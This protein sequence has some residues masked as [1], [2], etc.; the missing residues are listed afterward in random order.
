MKPTAVLSCFVSHLCVRRVI[1]SAVVCCSVLCIHFKSRAQAGC[2][3]LCT[4]LKQA[5]GPCCT[6]K[7][8]RVSCH[9]FFHSKHQ[10][11]GKLRSQH[12]PCHAHATASPSPSSANASYTTPQLNSAATASAA[13]H[14]LSSSLATSTPSAQQSSSS[15]GTIHG[16]DENSAPTACTQHCRMSGVG[17][18]LRQLAP[19][20][21]C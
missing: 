3:Y 6:N 2:V 21:R 1:L 14:S 20:S 4:M 17:H 12:K 15:S 18:V 13:V 11:H 10:H 16:P 9:L 8:A 7:A 5:P 19:I